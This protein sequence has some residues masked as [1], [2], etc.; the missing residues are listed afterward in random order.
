MSELS[1]EAKK[2]VKPSENR[3]G[4]RGEGETENGGEKGREMERGSKAV[5]KVQGGVE[6]MVSMT[7]VRC[8]LLLHAS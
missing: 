6:D 2:K 8:I 5:S 7:V 1:P 3:D 4:W